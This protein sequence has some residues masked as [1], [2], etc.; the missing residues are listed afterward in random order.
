MLSGLP[1]PHPCSLSSWLNAVRFWSHAKEGASC[2]SI[3]GFGGQLPSC[4][5]ARLRGNQRARLIPVAAVGLGKH[6]LPVPLPVPGAACQLS[7]AAAS[8]AGSCR[9]VTAG[10]SPSSLLTQPLPCAEITL[11]TEPRGH[12]S[13]TLPW[14]AAFRHTRLP[15]PQ[16]TG[17]MRRCPRI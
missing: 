12:Q 17:L 16:I 8:S 10:G 11:Q 3:C 1:Q 5:L 9:R 14:A 6:D 15:C 2:L 13:N 4:L 7:A